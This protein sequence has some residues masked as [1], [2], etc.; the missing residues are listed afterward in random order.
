MSK[1]VWP[2]L[3]RS[4][5]V[6]RVK[7]IMNERERARDGRSIVSVG[8]AVVVKSRSLFVHWSE[9]ESIFTPF[10]DS[11]K[12]KKLEISRFWRLRL[13]GVF[14]PP[15][16]A[17]LKEELLDRIQC[18]VSQLTDGQMDEQTSSRWRRRRVCIEK[19]TSSQTRAYRASVGNNKYNN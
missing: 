2:K 5:R 12:L 4:A 9:M 14:A 7:S 13:I 8:A 17:L 19:E 1:I 11:A 3:H 6:V 16:R 15:V 18:R 10:L